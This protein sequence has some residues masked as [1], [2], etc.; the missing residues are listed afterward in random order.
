MTVPV[1][2]QADFSKLNEAIDGLTEVRQELG[3]SRSWF[4]R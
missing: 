4:Q 3:Q 1:V 2:I